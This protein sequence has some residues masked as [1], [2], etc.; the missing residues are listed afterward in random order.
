V[1]EFEGIDNPIKERPVLAE[2]L[3]ASI[4][5][6]G[7]VA[8]GS[9]VLSRP[10]IRFQILRCF[11]GRLL[12]RKAA[13]LPRKVTGTTG[14]NRRDRKVPDFIDE[15][16]S[17]TERCNAVAGEMQRDCATLATPWRERCNASGVSGRPPLL[18]TLTI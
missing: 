8:C 3:S 11:E 12:F 9:S 13:L 10:A 6:T 4:G 14:K 2:S 16:G 7:L 1:I 15:T 5:V 18:S 17:F